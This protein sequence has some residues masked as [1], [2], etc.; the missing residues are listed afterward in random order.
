MKAI[1]DLDSELIVD[2]SRVGDPYLR[3]LLAAIGQKL[4]TGS[5]WVAV[6]KKVAATYELHLLFIENERRHIAA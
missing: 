1:I 4:A 6:N 5:S 3:L 2:R